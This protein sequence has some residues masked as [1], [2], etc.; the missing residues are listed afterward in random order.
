MLGLEAG[1]GRWHGRVQWRSENGPPGE[2]C[3]AECSVKGSPGTAEW[4]R[5]LQAPRSG[6]AEALHGVFLTCGNIRRAEGG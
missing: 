5:F 6:R 3:G 2:G 4:E 1:W